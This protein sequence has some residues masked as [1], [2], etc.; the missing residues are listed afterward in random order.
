MKENKNNLAMEYLE[1]SVEEAV[2]EIER[3]V[4][5]DKKIKR[6][7][8]FIDG[9]LCLPYPFDL[10]GTVRLEGKEMQLYLN[11]Q[12]SKAYGLKKVEVG[13]IIHDETV[14]KF[15]KEVLLQTIDEAWQLHLSEMDVLRENIGWRSYGQKDPL[16]EYQRESYELFSKVLSRIR[17]K[18]CYI[19]MTAT[20]FRFRGDK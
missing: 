2:S 9:C 16:L 19:L 4:T 20:S 11:K 15:E 10:E 1:R 13:E 12:V 5:I 17:V 7:K 6:L 8:S 3:C 14:K 18:F